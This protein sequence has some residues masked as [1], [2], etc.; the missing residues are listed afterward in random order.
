MILAMLLALSL[1][2]TSITATTKIVR[3][4]EKIVDFFFFFNGQKHFA[5]DYINSSGV[6]PSRQLSP[7]RD[8]STRLSPYVR[9][10]LLTNTISFSFD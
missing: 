2:I 3:Q 7:L 9:N 6:A 4:K 10:M 5:E 1:R 8:D